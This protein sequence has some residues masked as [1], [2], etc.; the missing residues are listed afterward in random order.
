MAQQKKFLL[1]GASSGFG[2]LVLEGLLKEG[3]VVYAVIRG[4]EARIRTLRPHLTTYFGHTLWVGDFDLKERGAPARLLEDFRE[5]TGGRDLDSLILNAGFGVYGPAEELPAQ[6]LRD[7]MEV[8]FFSAVE[9]TQLALPDL[10][11]SKGRIIAVSSLVGRFSLP[12]YGAY[13]ASKHALEGWFEALD[14]EVRRHGVRVHLIEP[15]GFKT[16]FTRQSGIFADLPAQSPYLARFANFKKVI[17]ASE[18]RLGNPRRIAQLILKLSG[19]SWPAGL[20]H[21]RGV[22][23]AFL[24]LVSRLLPDFLRRWVMRQVF[25]VV[26]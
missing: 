1:T 20:R 21:P 13:A 15:G 6:S 12:Y 19:S 10:R 23:A 8:N 25:R 11:R 18:T 2:A 4:G 22:D 3:H 7:Q 17:A 14:F 5:K 26:V 9:L 16:E 24:R